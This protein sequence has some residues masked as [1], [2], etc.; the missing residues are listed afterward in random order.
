MNLYRSNRSSLWIRITQ[1]H[2]KGSTDGYQE[3]V[4][5]RDLWMLHLD[6]CRFDKL[7]PLHRLY[8][9]SYFLSHFSLSNKWILESYIGHPD[10]NFLSNESMVFIAVAWFTG[11]PSYN[12]L[13]EVPLSFSYYMLDVSY[14][15]SHFEFL[16]ISH[17]VSSLDLV[18]FLFV[19]FFV[20]LL[21][22]FL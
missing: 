19:F 5:I 14:F 10:N 1:C 8:L 7:L 2:F 3:W 22:F 13:L 18:S 17:N 15:L 11:C 16:W 12:C 4:C 9:D 21:L 20:I 6:Y